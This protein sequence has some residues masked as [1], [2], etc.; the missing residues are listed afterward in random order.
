MVKEVSGIHTEAKRNA[1]GD[2]EVLDRR[3][4]KVDEMRPD[5]GVD[6]VVAERP[7]RRVS[8]WTGGTIRV[9]AQSPWAAY[10]PLAAVL[11]GRIHSA[12]SQ[13]RPTVWTRAR[14]HACAIVVYAR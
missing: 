7:T 1:L 10:D 6:R 5:Q 8:I 2:M 9:A 14:F 4:V 13:V 12:A 3:E 11:V